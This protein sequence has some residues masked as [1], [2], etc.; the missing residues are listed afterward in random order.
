MSNNGVLLEWPELRRVIL[1]SRCELS[2]TSLPVGDRNPDINDEQ[3]QAEIFAPNTPL[4]YIEL[5]RLEL[6]MLH[7][8]VGKVSKLRKLIL[9]SNALV[10]IPK[11]IGDLKEL[12]FLDLSINKLDRLPAAIGCLP[13]LSTLLLANNK[14]SSLPDMSNLVSLQHLDASHNQLTEFPTSF[15]IQSK[16]HTLILNSNYI[17]ELP[18]EVNSLYDNLKTVNLSNNEIAD[19]PFLFCNC[20]KIKTLELANNKFLDNRFKKLVEDPRHKTFALID[21]L[22]KKEPKTSIKNN[23]GKGSKANSAKSNINRDECVP[24]VPVITINYGMNNVLVERTKETLEIRPYIVCCILKD[25][26]LSAEKVKQLLNIQNKLHSSVCEERTIASIGTHN[27]RKLRVPLV[28]GAVDPDILMITPL[29]RHKKISGRELSS[30]LTNEAELVR[31]KEKRNVVSNTH[32]LIHVSH[33]K[34]LPLSVFD[35]FKWPGYKRTTRDELRGDKG[36]LDMDTKDIFVEVT[37]TVTKNVCLEIMDTFIKEIIMQGCLTNLVVEQVKIRQHNGEL[38]VAYPSKNDLRIPK[39]I[40]RRE[41]VVDGNNTCEI[42]KL[43]V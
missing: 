28:Y 32:K 4:N 2:L 26:S 18:T 20:K 11:D 27:F 1:E 37:S 41:L 25:C 21:Y 22:K 14:I 42:S 39:C 6:S 17:K 29:H 33:S 5:T 23:D 40:I 15:P 10:H 38:L 8:C 36:D 3:L 13:H 16:L 19:L 24:V 30:N 9:H 12:Q 35:G 7:T 34:A 31:K 43:E